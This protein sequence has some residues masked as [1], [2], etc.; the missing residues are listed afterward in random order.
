[1]QRIIKSEFIKFMNGY[2]GII[3][4]SLILGME[5]IYIIV[6]LN[7]SGSV[8]EN[9]GTEAMIKILSQYI[10]YVLPIFIIIFTSYIIAYD[11]K[12]GTAKFSL[13][14]NI[15]RWQF[16]VGKMIFILLLVTSS[17]I[18][19]FL[20]SFLIVKILGF[21]DIDMLEVLKAYLYCIPALTGIGFLITLIS[22]ILDDFQNSII[23]GI[24][25]YFLMII[26]DVATKAGGYF[27][28]TSSIILG[29]GSGMDSEIYMI[30]ALVYIVITFIINVVFINRK[31]IM[32]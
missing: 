13:I 10:L 20:S 14:S 25:M 27:T 29:Y 16:I 23:C 7:S 5:F 32:L 31:D 15:S 21:G 24:F 2:M 3:L 17:L 30:T 4:L 1:M 28:L 18:V 26:L 6:G 22:M 9:I 19:S 11:Y 8:I 12:N